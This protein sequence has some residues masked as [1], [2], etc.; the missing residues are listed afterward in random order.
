MS[1]PADCTAPA[2]ATAQVQAGFV[3]GMPVA[4]AVPPIYQSNAF[5]FAS[6]SHARDLFAHR[7]DGDIYS[8][9]A[10]PT[11][12][13]FEQRIAAL[14]GGVAAVGLASGQAACA[15]SL[16]A[17]AG[18]GGHIVAARQLYGGTVDLLEDTLPDWGVRT[19]FVDQ[20]DIDAW[21]AA[22]RPETR[23]FFAE[24]VA[25][26]IA[27]VLDVRAVADVAHAAGVPLVVDNTV[28]TPYL[29]RPREFGADISVH[30]ATKFI[31]GHGTVL[32]GA[33]VDLGTFDFTADPH[34]WPALTAPSRRLGFETSLV[35]R[36]AG[37]SPFIA[38][39]KGKHL[40]DL[41]PT[42][43]P[44]AAFALLQGLETLDLRMQRH[45][46]SAQRIAEHLDAHPAVAA[47][48]HPGL[49]HSP[50]HAASRT[51]LPRGVPSVFSIDLHPTGDAHADFAR[52]ERFVAGLRVLRLLANIGD[53]RSIVTHPASMTHSHLSDR[54]L[55]EA[56][57]S[58]TTVRISIGLEDP[59]DLVDDFDR[60]LAAL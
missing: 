54:Q 8:R 17:L 38:L 32:G 5:E 55:R 39:V 21:R 14:E 44:A 31:G 4:A 23:A 42:L 60:A 41:G 50:W 19:T 56:G 6:L 48:H 25:N 12:G 45:A 1:D 24:T 33:I 18:S 57:I 28:A 34:R 52:V 36:F 37:A 11:V 26:P 35:E 9:T 29:Q 40:H 27:Q 13:V 53:A 46:A 22:V 43:S 47:V 30:S 51:Y 20:D 3:A 59:D 58:Q 10:N 7:Q 2:F 15:L 16:L 49:A